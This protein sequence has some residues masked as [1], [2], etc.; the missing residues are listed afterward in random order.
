MNKKLNP[1]YVANADSWENDQFGSMRLQ[2]KLSWALTGVFGCVAMLALVALAALMPLKQFEPYL[3]VQDRS[4]GYLEVAQ[5]LDPKGLSEN[6]AV[7]AANVVRY[8]R[9][10]ETYNP[11]LLKSDFDMAQLYSADQASKDLSWAFSPS[12]QKSLSKIYGQDTQVSVYV[13][14]VSFLNKS[15]AS[16]RFS[17]KRVRDNAEVN[18]DWVGVLRFRVTQAPIKNQHRFDNPMGFQVTEYRR[19]QEATITSGSLK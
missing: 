15:T 8:L 3:V 2:L 6:E 7:M 5:K 18:E 12:N 13:K 1:D 4:T 10:R 19:D 14:S 17:T 11:S 16:V 9:A